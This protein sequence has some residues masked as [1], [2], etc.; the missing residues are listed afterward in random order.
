MVYDNYNEDSRKAMSWLE[1]WF[2][3]CSSDVTETAAELEYN[4]L[5]VSAT[6]AE[7]LF[8]NFKSEYTHEDG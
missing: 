6:D 5:L 1:F 3:M 4:P 2:F 8:D 7:N